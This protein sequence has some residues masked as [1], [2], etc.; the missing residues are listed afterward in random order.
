VALVIPDAPLSLADGTVESVQLL[1][2]SARFGQRKRCDQG[3]WTLE[4]L[5]DAGLDIVLQ[6]GGR[7][8]ANGKNA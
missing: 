4:I 7:E 5:L 8:K 2:A 3:E 1:P 6:H